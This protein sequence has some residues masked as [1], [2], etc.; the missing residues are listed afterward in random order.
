LIV[1]HLWLHHDGSPICQ[2]C[3]LVILD[4]YFADQIEF[5]QLKYSAANPKRAWS[6]AQLKIRLVSNQGISAGLKKALDARW[7]EPLENADI[8]QTTIGDLKRLEAETKLVIPEFQEFLNTLDFS[9]CGSHSRFVV[10]EKV[11]AVVAGLLGDDVSSEVRDFQVRVRELM[12]PERAGEIV[13]DKDILLW[14]GLSSREGLFPCPPDIRIPANAVERSADNG[15]ATRLCPRHRRVRKD[16]A[17]APNCRSF[18]RRIGDDLFRLLRW[19]PLR[20]L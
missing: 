18:A 17:Y 11:V 5:V 16:Y 2:S 1:C 13:T 20:L 10:R 15:R 4:G 9:E 14:F 8:D 6:V 19:R 7:S 3:Y 12:L